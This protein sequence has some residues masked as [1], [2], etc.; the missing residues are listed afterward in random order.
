MTETSGD[1]RHVLQMFVHHCFA[2]TKP[3]LFKRCA[4]GR[5]SKQGPPYWGDWGASIL[6]ILNRQLSCVTQ[7]IMIKI[8]CCK[9]SDDKD[10]VQS[11][12]IGC[13]LCKNIGLY[14]ITITWFSSLW[15]TK[16]ILWHGITNIKELI[17]KTKLCRKRTSLDLAS[18]IIG[19]GNFICFPYSMLSTLFRFIFNANQF[20]VHDTTTITSTTTTT[21]A[22]IVI[23]VRIII[24]DVSADIRFNLADSLLVRYLT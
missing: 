20:S 4:N 14:I 22:I 24:V 11:M 9:I 18:N 10:L 23:I 8:L 21:T 13:F 2:F 1:N 6:V 19:N 15:G 3:S 17:I 5:F 7:T 16:L 12:T